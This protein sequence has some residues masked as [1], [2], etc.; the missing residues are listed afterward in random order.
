M[1]GMVNVF[2]AH[3]VLYKMVVIRG[4]MSQG[5][6]IC[7]LCLPYAGSLQDLF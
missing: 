1:D 3:L 5:F 2:E 6:D 4:G 7:F